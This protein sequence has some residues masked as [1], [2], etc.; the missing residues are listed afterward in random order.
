M[1]F[2]GLF[3]TFPFQLLLM[4][5][6][7]LTVWGQGDAELTT[8]QISVRALVAFIIAIGLVRLAGRRAF[9]MK[10]PFDNTFAILIGSIM[11]RGV[12]G[13]NAFFNCVAACTVLAVLHRL[14]AYLSIKYSGFGAV[15]KGSKIPLFKDG[16]PDDDDER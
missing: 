3:N 14:F 15:V 4:N 1:N 11:A 5:E 6:T 2:C 13:S 8:T 12:V 7:I 9:G 10:S 16:K